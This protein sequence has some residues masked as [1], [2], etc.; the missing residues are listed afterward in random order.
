MQP[1]Q[2]S[3]LL[4]LVMSSRDRGD[5][6]GAGN[7]LPRAGLASALTAAALTAALSLGAAATSATGASAQRAAVPAKICWSGP[8]PKLA[9]RIARGV[10][11]AVHRRSAVVSVKVEDP[12]NHV[13]CDY[14]QDRQYY[15]ASVVKATILAALLRKLME[16]HRFLSSAQQALAFVHAGDLWKQLFE[17][18][19][20]KRDRGLGRNRVLLRA[21]NTPMLAACW[22]SCSMME[23]E[24]A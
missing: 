1:V 17:L 14:H 8:H 11:A 12:V 18:D 13:I 10:L 22:L 16:E 20:A 24:P 23:T 19:G 6:V 3:L 15:S 5:F 21:P 2:P 4:V 7:Y 9:A